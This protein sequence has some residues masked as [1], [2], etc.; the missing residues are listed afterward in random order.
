ME[1]KI[2]RKFKVGQEVE[3]VRTLGGRKNEY[4]YGGEV[5]CVSLHAKGKI[6]EILSEKKFY[7]KLENGIGGWNVHPDE[8]APSFYNLNN[9]V[10]RKVRK[11][12]KHPLFELASETPV[13]VFQGRVYSFGKGN[14]NNL[15]MSK[16][17]K[18]G[19]VEISRLESLD[20]LMLER[21]EKNI[22]EIQEKY[23]DRVLKYIGLR[24]KNKENVPEFI[25]SKVFSHFR[26]SGKQ[27][28]KIAKL[29]GNKS[30]KGTKGARISRSY[31]EV[32]VNNLSEKIKEIEKSI[33]LEKRSRNLVEYVD[34]K[35]LCDREIIWNKDFA[36]LDGKLYYLNASF[37]ESGLMLKLRRKRLFFRNYGSLR[38]AYDSYQE[39]LSKKIRLSALNKLDRRLLGIIKKNKSNACQNLDEYQEKDFGFL[40]GCYD[41]VKSYFVYLEV[42][43]FGIR[44]PYEDDPEHAYFLFKKSKIAIRVYH[45]GSDFN[46]DSKVLQQD[47]GEIVRDYAYCPYFCLHGARMPTEGR[48]AGEVIAK[49]LKR[50][51]RMILDGGSEDW[52]G[53]GI[54]GFSNLPELRKLGVKIRKSIK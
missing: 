39:A 52:Y 8:I 33:R 36:L 26:N 51:K 50:V 20:E 28:N 10:R 17:R 7:I 24:N 19:I 11:L 29:L 48:D 38:D 3:I 21:N 5:S 2:A 6:S 23:I 16:K 9:S 14:S 43:S 15:F 41:G 47:D 4:Y 35:D 42:P 13:F 34:D 1:L 53:A 12:E 49:R 45:D 44:D 37:R 32:A 54:Y 25:Y 27:E 40:T 18:E 30:K 46:Y 22:Q 31:L